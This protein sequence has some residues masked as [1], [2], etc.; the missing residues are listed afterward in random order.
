MNTH[1]YAPPGARTAEPGLPAAP[2]PVSAWLLQLAC[3]VGIAGMFGVIA[4]TIQRISM[5]EHVR[6]GFAA[7]HLA[8]DAAVLAWCALVFVGTQRRRPFGRRLGLALIAALFLVYA[9]GLARTGLEAVRRG[10][11]AGFTA[12]EWM[13]G[14]LALLLCGWWCR[15]FGWSKASRAWFCEERAPFDP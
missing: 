1:R 13:F 11:P 8:I 12:E 10:M 14:V 5:V 15:S 6:W 9:A 3:A 2:R 7:W 4:M